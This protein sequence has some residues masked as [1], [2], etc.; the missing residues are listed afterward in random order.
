MTTADR[1]TIGILVSAFGLA[2]YLTGTAILYDSV[3]ASAAG[4]AL[5]FGGLVILAVGFKTLIQSA[6]D[7]DSDTDTDTDDGA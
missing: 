2:T 7:A 1:Q 4:A 6:V 3:S 5:V